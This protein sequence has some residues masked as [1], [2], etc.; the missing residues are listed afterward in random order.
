M[1]ITNW[2]LNS[3]F[4]TSLRV[5]ESAT[6]YGIVFYIEDHFIEEGSPISLTP[7][8]YTAFEAFIRNK[9]DCKHEVTWNNTKT[10]MHIWIDEQTSWIIP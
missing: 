9:L 4:T 3:G 8:F 6:E 7:H 2:L 1:L 10:T 5:I